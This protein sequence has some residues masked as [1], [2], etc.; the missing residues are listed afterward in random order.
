MVIAKHT[1]TPHTHTSKNPSSKLAD[2]VRKQT[3][4][5][6][7]G[8]ILSIGSRRRENEE[9]TAWRSRKV[10]R[11]REIGRERERKKKSLV[12]EQLFARARAHGIP[13]KARERG[14]YRRDQ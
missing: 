6:V 13:K 2:V 7:Y 9:T 8:I 4:D 14:E 11:N 3:S 5:G 12:E 10:I 1:R